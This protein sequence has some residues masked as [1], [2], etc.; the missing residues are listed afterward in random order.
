MILEPGDICFCG[1]ILYQLRQTGYDSG[2]GV[3]TY[4]WCRV[5]EVDAYDIQRDLVVHAQIVYPGE[6][7]S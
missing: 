7:G 1:G 2:S 6:S 3:T 4:R 5:E